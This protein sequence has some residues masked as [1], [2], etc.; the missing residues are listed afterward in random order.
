MAFF[1]NLADPAPKE[2][3]SITADV[4]TVTVSGGALTD[5]DAFAAA[6]SASADNGG[7]IQYFVAN[8]ADVLLISTLKKQTDS[9]EPVLNINVARP[10]AQTVFGVPLLR[11]PAVPVGTIWGI[12]PTYAKVILRKNVDIDTSEHAAFTRDSVL[13]RA[14]MRIG[15]GFP[16]P[17][18][19]SRI[20]IT[21]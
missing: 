9:I 8:P 5:L 17:K 21:A 7:S 4:N 6:I 18:A 19:L 14:V 13:I 12:D 2:L 3:G 10:G 1:G 16:H 11:S 20:H 15:F